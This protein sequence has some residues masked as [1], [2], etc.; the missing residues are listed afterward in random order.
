MIKR[1][2]FLSI[3]LFMALLSF[4]VDQALKSWAHALVGVNGTIR[5]M[6][7][8]NIIATSNKGVAFSIATGVAPWIL[9]FVALGISA[10]LIAWLARTKRAAHAAGLGLALGGALGNVADRLRFGAVRDFIDV[11]WRE[12]HWPAFNLAD[13]AIVTGLAMVILLRNEPASGAGPS[14]NRDLNAENEGA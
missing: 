10:A 3:G 1:S 7:G 12:W 14:L 4:A 8:L 6:P 9:V 11:Y 5:F 2:R 13:A